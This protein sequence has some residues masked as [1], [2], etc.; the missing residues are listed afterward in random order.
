MSRR[1][2]KPKPSIRLPVCLMPALGGKIVATIPC[3]VVLAGDVPPVREIIRPGEKG[4][5]EPLFD[6]VG[7]RHKQGCYTLQEVR[8]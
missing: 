8:P 2:G 6:E 1:A 5:L 3:C 4:L 7:K